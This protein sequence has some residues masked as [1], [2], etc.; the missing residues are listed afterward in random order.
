MNI[1]AMTSRRLGWVMVGERTRFLNGNTKGFLGKC[2]TR[3]KYY[4]VGLDTNELIDWPSGF[5]KLLQIKLL[6]RGGMRISQILTNRAGYRYQVIT[7]T[8]HV[9]KS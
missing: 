2:S 1:Y 6:E 7:I 8:C 3:V 9:I 4:D 5:E